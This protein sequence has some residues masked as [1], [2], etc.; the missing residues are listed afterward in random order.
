ME[1]EQRKM[2]EKTQFPRRQNRFLLLHS[3]NQD[4]CSPAAVLSYIKNTLA[5]RL[6]QRDAINDNKFQ[7]HPPACCDPNL[8]NPPTLSAFF[9]HAG[10]PQENC[11]FGTESEEGKPDGGH[12]ELLDIPQK[13]AVGPLQHNCVLKRRLYETPDVQAQTHNPQTPNKK[14]KICTLFEDDLMASETFFC[15]ST[16]RYSPGKGPQLLYAVSP[17]KCG[18]RCIII[19]PE[20]IHLARRVHVWMPVC[21]AHFGFPHLSVCCS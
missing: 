16:S 13:P 8:S 7:S 15:L 20:W 11:P 2:K 18:Q 5:P 6:F 9:A 12:P 4:G 17:I 19:F 10:I 1:H 21:T 3:T 14:Y